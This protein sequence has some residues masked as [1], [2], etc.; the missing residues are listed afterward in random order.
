M[1]GEIAI[2]GDIHGKLTALEEIVHAAMNRTDVL[3]FV[4]DYVNRGPQSADVISFLVDLAASPRAD[5]LLA[6]ES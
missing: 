1:S 5:D 3:V 6:W 2:I 4:G